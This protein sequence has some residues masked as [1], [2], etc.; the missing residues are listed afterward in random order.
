MR[1]K[2]KVWKR[3]RNRTISC[4]WNDKYAGRH[5]SLV[6][7]GPASNMHEFPLTKCKSDRSRR[8][9]RS[10]QCESTIVPAD[11]ISRFCARSSSVNSVIE[12]PRFLLPGSLFFFRPSSLFHFDVYTPRLS[13][14]TTS[15]STRS[16]PLRSLVLCRE[17][18][19]QC[20]SRRSINRARTIARTCSR[21]SIVTE[22]Q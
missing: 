6:R 4:F 11:V 13:A 18:R 9:N 21:T 22:R 15:F 17:N 3:E 14:A 19:R 16:A 2:K 5:E 7:P 20:D 12:L 10:A 8:L 1:I